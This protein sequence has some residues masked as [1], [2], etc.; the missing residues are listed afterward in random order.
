MEDAIPHTTKLRLR[1]RPSCGAVG[2]RASD[3]VKRTTR[4]PIIRRDRKTERTGEIDHAF[5]MV[6]VDGSIAGISLAESSTKCPCWP[7]A[8]VLRHVQVAAER[9][10]SAAEKTDCTFAMLMDTRR[11]MELTAATRTT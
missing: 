1:A 11:P 2:Q 9:P 3:T 4:R 10:T 7:P 6:L 8:M 5:V